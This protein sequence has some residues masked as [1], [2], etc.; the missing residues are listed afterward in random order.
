MTHNI[1]K[2]QA[3]T[4]IDECEHGV[5]IVGSLEPVPELGEVDAHKIRANIESYKFGEFK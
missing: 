4:L 1:T 5:L 2:E 3:K